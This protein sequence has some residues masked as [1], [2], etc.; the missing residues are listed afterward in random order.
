VIAE[1]W[2]HLLKR[3]RE[4]SERESAFLAREHGVFSLTLLSLSTFIATLLVIVWDVSSC[5]RGE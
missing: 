2:Q 1:L 5:K 3:E 4:L